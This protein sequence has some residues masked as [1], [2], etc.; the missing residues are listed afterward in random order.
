MNQNKKLS[1]AEL[2]YKINSLI[3]VQIDIK[4]YLSK[5][6]NYNLCSNA[7]PLQDTLAN[8]PKAINLVKEYYPVYKQL[9]QINRIMELLGV[10]TFQMLPYPDNIKY[11][12]ELIDIAPGAE[13]INNI[14]NKYD[15]ET[16]DSSKAT[17]IYHLTHSYELIEFFISNGVCADYF[18]MIGKSVTY[19]YEDNA[20]DQA[21]IIFQEKIEFL[22]K[23]CRDV[24]GL[25]D[26]AKYFCMD[27]MGFGDVKTMELCFS[28][29]PKFTKEDKNKI[30][31]HFHKF[32]VSKETK[33]AYLDY[34]RQQSEE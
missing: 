4:E 13:I 2:I 18:K 22:L 12:Q 9:F 27:A 31:E 34:I 17:S 28:F 33:N 7:I 15:V 14:Y 29:N 16:F 26:L 6:R 21:L 25:P 23:N 30:K 11:T 20:S 10:F 19:F 1:F 3:F 24:A 32:G 5:D 8:I